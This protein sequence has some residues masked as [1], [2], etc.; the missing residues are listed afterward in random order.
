MATMLRDPRIADYDILVLQEPWRNPFSATTHHTARDI[1]HLCY[2]P[3]TEAEC[4]ARVCFFVNKRLDHTTW[5]F[6]SHS[7]DVCTVV[8]ER[9]GVQAGQSRLAIHNVYNAPRSS[10]GL[11]STFS[12]VQQIMEDYAT[13][14][15][16]VLGDFN[17]HHS[18][19]GGSR[20][21]YAD[22]EAEDK[23]FH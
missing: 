3:D 9:L 1:F 20:V 12:M 7:R 23:L 4:P 17:V 16:V 13:E 11:G 5:H 8:S 15:Q 19:W 14:G 10:G 6:T 2:P 22:R 18:M 21:R